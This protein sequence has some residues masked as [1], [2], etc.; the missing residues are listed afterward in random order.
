MKIQR[1]YKTKFIL[2]NQERGLFVRCAGLSRFVYNWGLAEWKAIFEAGEK[3]NAYGL[4]K[5]FNATKDDEFPWVRELPYVIVQE[6]FDNLGRAFQNFFRQRKDGTVA[7]RID[8]MK[9]SG[10]WPLRLAKLLKKGKWGIEL[11]PGYPQFKSRHKSTPA[12]RLRG[13]IK[14]EGHRVK[15]PI[16]GWFRLA[17]S[18]YLPTDVKINSAN[19]QERAGEWYISL[20]VEEDAPEVT[21]A[22]GEP[23]GVDMG[24]KSLAVVS[25]GTTFDNP[26]TLTKHE[27]RL[28]RLSRELSRRK[29]GSA[30]RQKTKAKIAELHRKIADTRKHTLHNIS[31]HVTAKTKPSAVVV[32]DLNVKGMMANGKLAKAVADSSMGE[33]RRQIEY[34]ADWN[35]VQVVTADRWFPSSKTC[36]ECGYINAELTLSD[37]VWTCESCGTVLD[38][39]LNAAK[40]LARLA[41]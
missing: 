19:I 29:K 2:N 10:E 26:K 7:G 21:P 12:F 34:K 9:K 36:C 11:E 38:R 16:L 8:A 28:A 30:N 22:T 18:D 37:R 33:L 32:E 17:E 23:I 20:Q 35:G 14:V 24:I 15:L 27:K 40:N 39:D 4:K 3:P 1:A 6:T 5:K 25:D 13:T 31:R 41:A